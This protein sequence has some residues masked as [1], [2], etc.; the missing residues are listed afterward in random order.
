L[1]PE[2]DFHQEPPLELLRPAKDFF[3]KRTREDQ[4][5]SAEWQVAYLFYLLAIVAGGARAQEISAL[6]PGD[7][8]KG[9]GWALEQ[10][11]VGTRP[12]RCFA[13]RATGCRQRPTGTNGS[14]RACRRP[15][16]QAQKKVEFTV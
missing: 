5:G 12:R 10:P 6:T 7:L 16:E 3:K 2:L 13:R 8:L 15:R 9:I 4:R 11:W 14:R 1:N